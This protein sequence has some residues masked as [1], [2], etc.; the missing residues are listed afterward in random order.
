MDVYINPPTVQEAWQDRHLPHYDC[1]HRVPEE[2]S[3]QHQEGVIAMFVLS[4]AASLAFVCLLTLA[5]GSGSSAALRGKDASY[6]TG[7]G[8]PWATAWRRFLALASVL[9]TPT[10]DAANV[11]H[12]SARACMW[13]AWSQSAAAN[14]P[15]GS[16]GTDIHANSRHTLP[17]EKRR[18]GSFAARLTDTDSQHLRASRRR[19]FATRQRGHPHQRLAD[20]A[21][22]GRPLITDGLTVHIVRRLSGEVRGRG[23]LR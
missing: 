10:F 2:C 20:G 15:R 13:C 17:G 11:K 1:P 7:S 22:L 4:V 18:S 14:R 3:E 8:H 21:D 12:S 5:V 19:P 6:V 23:T 9:H 16:Q